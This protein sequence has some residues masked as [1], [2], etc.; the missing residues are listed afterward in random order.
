[1]KFNLKYNH[2]NWGPYLFECQI[3]PHIIDRLTVEGMK[4]KN[5]RPED[6][7][8]KELVGHLK[9]Q[10]L[11]P[12]GVQEWFY[13]EFT[14]YLQAYRHGHSKY[15][16]LDNLEVDLQPV[17]LWI[18]YMKPGDYNPPHTHGGDYSFVIFLDVPEELKKEMED[19]EGTASKPGHLL[20]RYGQTAKPHWASTEIPIV[21]HTG[22]CYIFPAL[23]E[24]TVNPF[25]SNITRVSVSGNI[26]IANR[27]DLPK[28]YY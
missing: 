21:P 19:F 10:Y 27:R 20:F 5:F 23:L 18:N 3:S 7:Y 22:S 26:E 6:N 4:V 8:N 12:V 17:D 13:N 28:D 9:H 24:H 25:K 14:P 11:Y 16:G 15:H 2:F 1:M